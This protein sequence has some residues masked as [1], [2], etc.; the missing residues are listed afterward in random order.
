M[1]QKAQGD[2][3]CHHARHQCHFQLRFLGTWS[4]IN[5]DG[6]LSKVSEGDEKWTWADW[7]GEKSRRVRCVKS[8][9]QAGERGCWVGV[10]LVLCSSCGASCSS[11]FALVPLYC[12]PLHHLN[13]SY[14]A[15]CCV[16]DLSHSLISQTVIDLLLVCRR[17]LRKRQSGQADWKKINQWIM[18]NQPVFPCFIKDLV[19]VLVSLRLQNCFC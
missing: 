1:E 17:W 18:H 10:V 2:S 9:A 14:V 7:I 5:I 19:G 11:Y 16:R 4:V 15:W 8:H 6:H 12:L 13:I 3:S